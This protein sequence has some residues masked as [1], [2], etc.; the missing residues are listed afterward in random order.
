MAYAAGTIAWYAAVTSRPRCSAG[1]ALVAGN[2]PIAG[3]FSRRVIRAAITAWAMLPPISIFGFLR[4]M[5]VLIIFVGFTFFLTGVIDFRCICLI[6]F[7]YIFGKAAFNRD[8]PI[9][10]RRLVCSR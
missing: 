8:T 7:D 3:I 5:V 1:H 9:N 6:R 2:C 4:G 10:H